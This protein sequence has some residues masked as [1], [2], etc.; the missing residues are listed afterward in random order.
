MP[1]ST[2]LHPTNTGMLNVF[3][4]RYLEMFGDLERDTAPGKSASFVHILSGSSAPEAAME[5][6]IGGVMRVGV[7]CT[8]LRIEKTPDGR[9]LVEYE[10]GRRVSVVSVFQSSP[11]MIAAFEWFGDEDPEDGAQQ[12][13]VLALEKEV[14]KTLLEIEQLM[15]KLGSSKDSG[16]SL[17]PGLGKYSPSLDP[18]M[19]SVDYLIQSGSR[20]GHSISQWMRAG[21][22]TGGSAKSRSG[23]ANSPM[24]PYE[25]VRDS[26]HPQ[27]SEL[28]SFAA[29][30]LLEMGVPERIALL[31]SQD[32]GARLQVSLSPIPL[33]PP[34]TLL[35]CAPLSFLGSYGAFAPSVVGLF[36]LLSSNGSCSQS[37]PLLRRICYTSAGPTAIEEGKRGG[38]GFPHPGAT[39][40]A[41]LSPLHA[42]PSRAKGQ[43]FLWGVRIATAG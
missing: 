34:S 1:A 11:Y 17:P 22:A 10:G 18:S 40:P 19:S 23:S 21:T 43:T 20:A 41:P 29:A 28:F 6:S 25:A 31:R 27:R 35:P 9:M 16:P 8:V 15:K 4:P 14:W 33:C 32:T 5:D 37:V 26:M 36:P 24:D 30:S 12:K 13:E 7:L 39:A 38:G 2:V 3:E 42:H